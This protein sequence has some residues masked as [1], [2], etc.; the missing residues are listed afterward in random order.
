MTERFIGTSMLRVL[1]HWNP[2][3]TLLGKHRL[4]SAIFIQAMKQSANPNGF[5]SSAI[6]Y[7]WPLTLVNTQQRVDWCWF[8]W[9]QHHWSWHCFIAW[10]LSWN[11]WDGWQLGI[12][13]CFWFQHIEKHHTQSNHVNQTISVFSSVCFHLTA[14]GEKVPINSCESWCVWSTT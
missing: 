2:I 13:P 14:S 5:W 8:N 10:N 3:A 9:H 6:S 11:L 1:W 4:Q 12:H 7:G